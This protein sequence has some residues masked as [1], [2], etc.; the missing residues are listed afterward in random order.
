MGTFSNLL[1]GVGKVVGSIVDLAIDGTVAVGKELVNLAFDSDNPNTE[2]KANLTQGTRNAKLTGFEKSAIRLLRWLY[3]QKTRLTEF[4][5][6]Y[7]STPRAKEII[8]MWID[9]QAELRAQWDREAFVANACSLAFERTLVEN[10][11][12]KKIFEFLTAA[13][14]DEASDDEKIDLFSFAYLLLVELVAVYHSTCTQEDSDNLI[15]IGTSIGLSQEDMEECINNMDSAL[16]SEEENA[17]EQTDE[18]PVAMEEA[19][20]DALDLEQLIGITDADSDAEKK[21][22]LTVAYRRYNNLTTNPDQAI[23]E[24]A[25]RMVD[26][27]ASYRKKL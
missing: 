21:R 7:P 14:R 18:S 27:I 4:D 26:L 16:S 1:G 25:K 15:R 24:N 19:V 6:A 12:P 8:S 11:Q 10:Q 5:D 23:A 17:E 3:C 20:T 9:S 13:I 22:K 2:N